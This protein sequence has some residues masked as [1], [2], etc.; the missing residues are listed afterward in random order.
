MNGILVGI[1]ILLL[2]AG[3]VTGYAS[4]MGLAHNYA[5]IRP[6]PDWLIEAVIAIA[7]MGVGAF[8]VILG[9]KKF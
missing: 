3:L 8:M 7:L 9:I 2:I 4:G 6:T 5:S 1:G